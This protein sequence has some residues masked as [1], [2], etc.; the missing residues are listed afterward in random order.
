MHEKLMRLKKYFEQLG[1][2]A[3]A[4][5]SGVDSTFLLAVAFEVLGN[6]A[7][8]VTVQS[9]TYPAR[10]R[11]EAITFCRE[12]GIPHDI[13]QTSELDIPGFRDNPP[14]RCYLCKQHIFTI[15]RE[16][17]LKHGI[18]NIAEGSNMDDLGDYRPG[19]QA[20]AEMGVLSPLREVGLYKSE[21]RALSKEMGLPTWSKPSFACLSSR[22]AYGERI[23]EKRLEMVEKAEDALLSLHILQYRVRIHGTIARIEVAP[24]DFQKVIDHAAWI[25]ETLRNIGFSYVTLD[26]GGYRMGSMN[27]AL[28]KNSGSED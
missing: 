8:A 3:I 2:V 27:D 9:K 25:N 14:N 13:V 22:F 7:I 19:L 20:T 10:E 15:I 1:S 23:D 12:R 28:K 21:I 24:Q 5:S 11:N 17:A 16:D 6:K 26:L 18:T 4:F